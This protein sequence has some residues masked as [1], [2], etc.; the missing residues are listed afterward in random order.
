[1]IA[2][3]SPRKMYMTPTA[4]LFKLMWGFWPLAQAI[5]DLQ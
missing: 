1:M 5:P 2:G 4:C 3:D